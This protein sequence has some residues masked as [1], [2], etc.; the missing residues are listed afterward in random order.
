M[1]RNNNSHYNNKPSHPETSFL[2][3]LNSPNYPDDETIRLLQAEQPC[4]NEK[5]PPP[6]TMIS[7]AS[8]L[9]RLR[10]PLF[11]LNSLTTYQPHPD[12]PKTIL[13]FHLL[14]EAQL[15]ALAR[16]YHQAWI[17][18]AHEMDVDID[19]KRRLFGEFIGLDVVVVPF[20]NV[21]SLEEVL[22]MGRGG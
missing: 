10:R 16:Y 21:A 6:S 14:T 13:S 20:Q 2:D 9:Q 18:A 4:S 5:N 22:R 7:F 12:F 3:L 1:P 8:T 17:G 19:E 15:D 11:A